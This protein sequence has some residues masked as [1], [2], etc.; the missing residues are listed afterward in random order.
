MKKNPYVLVFSCFLITF[1][2][3]HCNQQQQQQDTSAD[4]EAIRGIN[5]VWFSSYNSR[6]VN[7][8]VALYAE[9]AVVSPP[10]VSP[11]RSHSAISEYLTKDIAAS[12]EAGI[13]F[14]GNAPTEVGV[15]GDLGWEWGTFSVKDSSGNIVE[16]GKYVSVFAKKDGKWFIIRDI[17]NK[18]TPVQMP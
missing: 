4:E 11:L 3:L 18:D 7:S 10:G 2:A 17:W 5:P 12:K 13:T 14:S 9:D 8:I 16:T 1:F 6:D 15:S